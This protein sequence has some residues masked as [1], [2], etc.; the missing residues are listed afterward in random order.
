MES[1]TSVLELM[2]MLML[3]AAAATA[4]GTLTVLA[5]PGALAV[6]GIGLLSVSFV[7][8]QIGARR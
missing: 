5:I 3:V 6:A 2:G 1:V 8:T 7:V 4:V